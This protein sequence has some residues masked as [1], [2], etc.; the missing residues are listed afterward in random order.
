MEVKGSTGYTQG[1]MGRSVLGLQCFS[2]SRSFAHSVSDAPLRGR[3]RHFKD[4]MA[5]GRA[6]L[7][8]F[9]RPWT[10]ILLHMVQGLKGCGNLHYQVLDIHPL[11]KKSETVIATEL[12]GYNLCPW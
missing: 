7:S 9:G 2:G 12:R 3:G 5:I 1:T 6:K 10:S 11:Q 8:T 4:G